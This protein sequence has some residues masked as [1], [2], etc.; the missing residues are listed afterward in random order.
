MRAFKKH[1]FNMVELALAIAIVAIGISSTMT[2]IPLSLK[3]NTETKIKYYA[4]DITDIANSFAEGVLAGDWSNIMTKL[5]EVKK[6]TM[7]KNNG[8]DANW[9]IT[10][11]TWD[12]SNMAQ[13]N[14]YAIKDQD[15]QIL[16]GVYGLRL[17]SNTGINSASNIKAELKIWKTPENS[18]NPDF[19]EVTTDKEDIDINKLVGINME[20]S[21]PAE[22]PYEQREKFAYYFEVFNYDGN[23]LD[24]VDCSYTG[25]TEQT[26]GEDPDPTPEEETPEE[27]TPEETTPPEPNIEKEEDNEIM[28]NNTSTL[29]INIIASEL[30]SGYDHAPVYVRVCIKEPNDENPEGT[31][32]NIF[33]GE[34]VLTSMYRFNYDTNQL[35]P[36]NRKDFGSETEVAALPGQTWEIEIPSG[37][38]YKIWAGYWRSPYNRYSYTYSY[39]WSHG[40]LIKTYNYYDRGGSY[41]ANSYWST[42][43][44]QVKT[45]LN[46]DAVSEFNKYAVNSL[47]LTPIE[48][49]NSFIGD[50]GNVALDDN[51]VLYLFELSHTG[52][53]G[54]DLQ[55]MIILAEIDQN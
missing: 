38:T 7:I 14:I 31:T 35:S 41:I 25:P 29:R 30:A 17:A 32:Y 16:N 3:T 55:D 53:S 4:S 48:C 1:Y 43:D 15:G 27:G 45:L 49:I 20:I 5:P 21:C 19:G 47:Q 40:H 9:D 8:T 37:S 36:D 22:K 24:P 11:W 10:K 2:I 54:Y 46:G 13:K 28:V 12:N 18:L 39:S 50:D 34:D 51:Q 23:N 26:V 33:T 6:T 42:N 44:A 52:G